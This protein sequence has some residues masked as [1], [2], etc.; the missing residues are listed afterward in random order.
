MYRSRW[1][2]ITKIN[3]FWFAQEGFGGINMILT[4]ITERIKDGQKIIFRRTDVRDRLC[5]VIMIDCDKGN[6]FTKIKI[7][8]WWSSI[9]RGFWWCRRFR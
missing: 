3:S 7:D 6:V 9:F 4:D 8:K 2:I 5:V 1:E